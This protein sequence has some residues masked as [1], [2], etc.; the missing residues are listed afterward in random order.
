[1]GNHQ[2]EER[3]ACTSPNF[4]TLPNFVI[5]SEAKDLCIL[6][7]RARYIELV[8]Q[9]GFGQGTASAVPFRP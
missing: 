8:S 7:A 9:I 2:S 5:L 3:P 1:M 4:V 6:L